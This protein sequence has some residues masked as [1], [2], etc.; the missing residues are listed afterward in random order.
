MNHCAVS[1]H[2]LTCWLRHKKLVE[3]TSTDSDTKRRDCSIPNRDLFVTL[4]L[5]VD[6]RKVEILNMG[7]WVCSMLGIGAPHLIVLLRTL[8]SET[9]LLLI[10]QTPLRTNQDDLA[11]ANHNSTDAT[12]AK[13]Q[14]HQKVHTNCSDSVCVY[15]YAQ[16]GE[17]AMTFSIHQYLNQ[18]LPTVQIS[19]ILEEV[20]QTARSTHLLCQSLCS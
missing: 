16:I 1:A 2:R 9:S 8:R 19:V 12:L 4:Q 3:R 5:R 13:Y 10:I 20:I 17:N 14:P 15:R 18:H 7:N 11:I 6:V